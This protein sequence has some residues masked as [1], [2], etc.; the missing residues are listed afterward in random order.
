M[1]TCCRSFYKGKSNLRSWKLRGKALWGSC[2]QDRKPF[3]GGRDSADGRNGGS[4]K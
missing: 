4:L 3:V 2:H 1:V